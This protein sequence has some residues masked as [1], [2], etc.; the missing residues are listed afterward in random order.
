MTS[1]TEQARIPFIPVTTDAPVV[2]NGDGQCSVWCY[3]QPI[4]GS[5]AGATWLPLAKRTLLAFPR[6]SVCARYDTGMSSGKLTH[7]LTL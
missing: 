5:G 3:F 4:P 7:K 6:R 1:A 2:A